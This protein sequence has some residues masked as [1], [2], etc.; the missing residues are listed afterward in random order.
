MF[1]TSVSTPRPTTIGVCIDPPRFLP[2]LSHFLRHADSTRCAT[3]R[4]PATTALELPGPPSSR[5]DQSNEHKAETLG[6]TVLF[7]GSTEPP[8]KYTR[9]D[10]I[11]PPCFL[12]T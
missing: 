9:I 1:K 2:I 5:T 10:S 4:N 11:H 6:A 8:D 12:P 3:A 7:P